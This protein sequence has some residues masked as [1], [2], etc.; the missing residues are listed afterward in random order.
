MIALVLVALLVA[1]VVG[2]VWSVTIG[3]YAAAAAL[4]TF[5]AVLL[6]GW[7]RGEPLP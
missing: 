6:L 3:T 4:V 1:L 5:L 7:R 2:I